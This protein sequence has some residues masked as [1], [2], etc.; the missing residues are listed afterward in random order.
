MPLKIEPINKLTYKLK[1]TPQ[2]KLSTE[3]LQL[4]FVKLQEF[5]KQQIEENPLLRNDIKESPPERINGTDMPVP[6][7][8]SAKEFGEKNYS[9]GEREK[10]D[11]RES[12]ITK[13]VTLHEHLL[14]QLHL[15]ASSDPDCKIGELIIGDIDDNGYL[16]SSLK[17][18]S[19]SAD[20]D[21]SRA[22]KVL[23]L[24]QTF[25]PAGAGA[26]D[27]R[28]CLMLQLKVTGEE[29]SLAGRIID[30]FLPFLAKKRYSYIASKLKV[31]E[32]K[33]KQ[34][35]KEITSLEPKP[36]RSF[37]N[38][39]TI[40]LIP[41]AV[42]Q[43]N[44]Q[45]YEISFNSGLPNVRLN[46]KYKQMLS[47]ENTAQDVKK[48]LKERLKA[49]NFL[50]EAIAKRKETLRKVIEDI[51]CIQKDFLDNGY[52]YFK[53]MTLEQIATR[54]GKHKSTVSR[55]IN[56]K[57]V[58]TP[59]GILELR[60]FLNSGIKQKSGESFSSKAIKVKI[61][62]FI[63]EENKQKPL[64]DNQIVKLL[65][66]EKIS[67]AVRTVTKYRNQLKIPSSKMRKE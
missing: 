16:R 3:L 64:N 67:A 14:R 51:V 31:S 17:E 18:I 60:H 49:A 23:S 12:L 7:S 52:D 21:I 47:Q 8:I 58:Q 54:I 35:L 40:R 33:V 39:I 30:K 1:F 66:Q 50:I 43:K 61:K 63:A 44:N 55:A 28:E 4:P 46:A 9:A 59:W 38:E 32:E 45:N 2:M 22:E 13:P 53:P 57:C 36:G 26:K 25:D 5:I 29:N 10:Q 56:N 20:T 19:E 11:F 37:N 34:A 15:F 65:N 48:Y 6:Y 41:E 27:L 42:I 62:E 24:I